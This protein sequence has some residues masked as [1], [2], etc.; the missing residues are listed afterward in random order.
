[1]LRGSSRA[2]SRSERVWLAGWL[3]P[4]PCRWQILESGNLTVFPPGSVWNFVNVT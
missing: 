1:M 3:A 4:A 2:P